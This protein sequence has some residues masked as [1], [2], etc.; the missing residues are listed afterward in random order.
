V[1]FHAHNTEWGRAGGPSSV[2]SY[3]K[4]ATAQ[5]VDKI[6]TASH[7]RKEDLVRHGWPNSRTSGVWNDVDPEQSSPSDCKPEDV[8]TIGERY[9][10][11]PEGK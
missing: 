8:K 1:A 9:G 11:E 7:A 2:F 6:M 4:W 5:K 10:I 3:L